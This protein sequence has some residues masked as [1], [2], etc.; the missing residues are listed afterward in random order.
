MNDVSLVVVVAMNRE[1]FLSSSA[2]GG[3]GGGTEG[4]TLEFIFAEAGEQGA[5]E[6]QFLERSREMRQTDRQTEGAGGF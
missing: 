3:G 5:P 2:K 6:F 4:K 1:R